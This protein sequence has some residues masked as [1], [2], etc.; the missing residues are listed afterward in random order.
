MMSIKMANSN[1]PNNSVQIKTEGL[2]PITLTPVSIPR[3]DSQIVAPNTLRKRTKSTK[4][5]IR[6]IAGEI[7]EAFSA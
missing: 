4:S 6:M 3:K 1:L 5:V 2:Q 7:D